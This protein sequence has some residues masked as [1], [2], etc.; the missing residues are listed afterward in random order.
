MLFDIASLSVVSFTTAFCQTMLSGMTFHVAVAI[1]RLAL[2][3]VA[4]MIS[5]SRHN[6]LLLDETVPRCYRRLP[7]HVNGFEAELSVEVDYTAL[8]TAF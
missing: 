3:H 1:G 4:G 2:E 8:E 7:F 6:M 5:K